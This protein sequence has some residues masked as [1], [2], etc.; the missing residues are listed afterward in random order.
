MKR[1]LPFLIL[2]GCGYVGDVRPPAMYIPQNI[3]DLRGL[4]RGGT[5]LVEASLPRFTTEGLTIDDLPK[6]EVRYGPP[7]PPG[8]FDVNAWGSEARKASA[9]VNENGLLRAALS[10]ADLAGKEIF[11]S[12]RTA[13]PKGR[14]SGWSNVLV[15]TI[16][17]PLATP[18]SIK[19]ESSPDGVRLTWSGDAPNY[20]VFRKAEGEEDFRLLAESGEAAY[21]DATAEYGKKYAYQLQGK[22]RVNNRDDE[23][24]VSAVVEI[25]PVDTFPPAVPQGLSLLLAVSSVEVAW[26]R[27]L[28]KD[29]RGYY[30]YRASSG[31][32]LERISDL[33]EVPAFSDRKIE[34]GKSY[35]YA[36]T[37]VDRNGNESAK[38]EPA[39][40]TVAQ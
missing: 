37:S 20:R 14:W 28:D 30:V 23:S 9:V 3:Q 18:V 7:P 21:T 40:I 39:S 12:A 15:L 17:P 11:V 6:L 38:T 31:A 8:N 34:S 25:T 29:L 22:R 27:N 19:P 1:L 10:I 33:L 13:T 5:L 32:A 24:E 36:V 26:E 35:S 4:Q 2:T 16:Q